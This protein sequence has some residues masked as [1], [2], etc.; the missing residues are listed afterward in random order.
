M[1]KTIALTAQD[2]YQF[3]LIAVRYNLG[4][5][6]YFVGWTRRQVRAIA[7]KLDAIQRK[8][9]TENIRGCKDYGNIHDKE[10]R[11]WLLE[12]LENY[13]APKTRKLR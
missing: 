11:L 9:I 12:W 2:A 13:D 7:P 4:G 8:I 10:E 6:S 3:L 1:K 5:R